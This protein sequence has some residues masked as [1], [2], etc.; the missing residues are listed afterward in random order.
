MQITDLTDRPWC[1]SADTDTNTHYLIQR[2]RKHLEIILI[3]QRFYC[4]D[5]LMLTKNII[6]FCFVTFYHVYPRTKPGTI[7]RELSNTN[8][9]TVIVIVKL[10]NCTVLLDCFSNLN[11]Q[12]L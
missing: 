8:S 7:I 11:Q 10:C 4:K 12:L 3:G 6:F 9:Q 5:Q 2:C 1:P